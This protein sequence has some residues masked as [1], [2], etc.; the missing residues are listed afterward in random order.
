MQNKINIIQPEILVEQIF[1]YSIQSHEAL[2]LAKREIKSGYNFALIPN[3]SHIYTGILQTTWHLMLDSSKKWLVLFS[4]QS[5]NPEKIQIFKQKIWP[6][7]WFYFDWLDFS[8]KD[9]V[10]SICEDIPYELEFQLNI[11]RIINN[12]ESYIH[13]GIW[14]NVSQENISKLMKTIMKYV[15]S[16]NYVFLSNLSEN[17]EIKQCKSIDAKIIEAISLWQNDK[18]DIADNNILNSFINISKIRKTEPEIVMYANS[19]DLDWN[20]KKTSWYV[21][22]VC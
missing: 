22:M 17:Q 9:K 13:F 10:Y 15:D 19:W 14:E 12:T 8:S 21:C 7:L 18:Q 11:A 20:R 3:W 5:D 4:N 6:I 2:K 16:C 1:S